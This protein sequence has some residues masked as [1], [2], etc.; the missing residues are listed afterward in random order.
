MIR[1]MG[2]SLV[3]LASDTC[4]PALQRGLYREVGEL[5]LRTPSPAWLRLLRFDC[6]GRQPDRH[7][8]SLHKATLVL[9]PIS[10][11]V[12]DLVFGVDA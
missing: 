2:P 8:P 9:A 7:D 6:V 11:A 5:R 3:R 1:S 10:H 12:A 4:R